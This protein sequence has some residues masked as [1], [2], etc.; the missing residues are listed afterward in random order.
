MDP[1]EQLAQSGHIRQWVE[2]QCGEWHHGDWVDFIR[3]ATQRYGPLP[4][5]RVGLL[6]EEE[7]K[8][9]WA[10]LAAEERETGYRIHT[11]KQLEQTREVVKGRWDTLGF[12]GLLECERGWI[13]VWWLKVETENGGLHQY[14]LNSSG[15][16][17]LLALEALE[18]LEQ[19]ETHRILSDALACFGPVGGFSPVREER[20]KKLNQLPDNVFE[21]LTKAFYDRSENP[22]TIALFSVRL[23]HERLGIT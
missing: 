18:R 3:Q 6:L 9:Y 17:A 12:D 21:A 20:L 4:P 22:D 23:E 5:D 14:F 7:K 1:L 10:R 15:D 19:T 16:G 2:W 8:Q 11:R 13:A